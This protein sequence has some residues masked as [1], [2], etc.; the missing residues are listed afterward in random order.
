MKITRKDLKKAI[1]DKLSDDML[2]LSVGGHTITD[3]LVYAGCSQWIG[4]GRD[5]D[6]SRSDYAY[7]VDGEYQLTFP[8]LSYFDGHNNIERQSEYYLQPDRSETPPEE[9]IG[10]PL[11]RVPDHILIEIAKGLADTIA[12]R[13]REQREQDQAAEDLVAKLAGETLSL[14]LIIDVR[15]KDREQAESVCRL[16]IEWERSLRGDGPSIPVSAKTMLADDISTA[17]RG[18]QERAGLVAT[19]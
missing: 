5:W 4:C 19:Y 8:N 3:S 15:V 6:S 16:L 13:E 14:D 9:P 10:E 12:T 18:L 1:L 7:I 11:L 17:R 2:P